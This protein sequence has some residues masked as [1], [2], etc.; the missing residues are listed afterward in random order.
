MI[1]KSY[2]FRNGHL[3]IKRVKHPYIPHLKETEVIY[4]K[5]DDRQSPVYPVS[6]Y[7]GQFKA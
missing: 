3:I 6:I 4:I 7:Q 1:K 2:K 5:L